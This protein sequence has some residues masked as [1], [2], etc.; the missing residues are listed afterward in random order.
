M[1]KKQ[2]PQA[3]EP[4]G[5]TMDTDM[6]F[7]HCVQIWKGAPKT[8][9]TSTAAALAEAAKKYDLGFKP[10]FL[11]FEPGSGGVKLDG[12]NQPCPACQGSGKEGK[13]PCPKCKGTG[14]VRLILSEKDEIRKAFEW[15]AKSDFNPIIIDTGDAMFQAVMD[16][17]AADMGLT[18]PFGANDNGICWAMI[19]DAMRELLGIITAEGKALI[20]IMHVTMQEKR[21]KGGGSVQVAVFNV[22]GKTRTYM[23]GLADQI[24]HFDVV[25]DPDADGDMHVLYGKPTAG[26][27]AGDRYGKFPEMLKLGSSPEE[28]ALA[29]LET[30]GLIELK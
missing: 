1:A 19:F 23:A 22:A 8:G 2:Q 13:K 4:N 20:I 6:D 21:V 24:L 3:S 17:T 30:F 16:Y 14:I 12:T 28:G 11:L 5:T 25:P 10:Y 15:A 7:T 27:E 9:K 29:I 18:S 26:I